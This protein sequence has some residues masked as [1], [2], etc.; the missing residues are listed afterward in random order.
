LSSIE[1]IWELLLYLF[2]AINGLK[3]QVCAPIKYNAFY[4]LDKLLHQAVSLRASIIAH[5]NEACN[6]L[7]GIALTIELVEFGRL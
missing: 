3:L 4:S 7:F 5:L 1:S 2:P 6:M